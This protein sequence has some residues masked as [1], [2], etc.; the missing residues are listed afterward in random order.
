[1]IELGVLPVRYLLSLCTNYI[2]DI[3]ISMESGFDRVEDKAR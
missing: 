3:L 2:I 1:M